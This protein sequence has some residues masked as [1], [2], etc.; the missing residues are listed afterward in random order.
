MRFVPTTT[1]PDFQDLGRSVPRLAPTEGARLELLVLAARAQHC[2]GVDTASGVL[3]RAWFDL[4]PHD[5]APHD[6]APHDPEPYDPEPSEDPQPA[7]DRQPPR[8]LRTYDLAVV[9]LAGDDEV[10]PDPSPEALTLAGPPTPAGRLTGRRAERL[11]RP[12]L[13]PGGAPLLGTRASA[14]PLWARRPDQPSMAVVQPQGPVLLRRSVSYLACRFAWAGTVCELACLDGRLAGEMD[15]AGQHQRV[16]DKG[17][18]LVVAFTPPIEGRCHKVVEA[19][20]PR[21]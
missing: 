4:P 21:L 8:R 11:L 9:T 20:L 3:V 19:V 15:R 14:L 5:L 2:A 17:T 1:A 16:V 18:R 6:P 7:Y 10:A 13:H 12:L